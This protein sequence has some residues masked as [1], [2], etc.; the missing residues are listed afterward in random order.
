[1]SKASNPV[2]EKTP[3]KTPDRPPLKTSTNVP[4]QFLF[5]K[6]NYTLMFIGLGVIIL[7]FILMAG[8]KSP[9]PNVF[10]Y[11]EIYS[12]RRITIAPILVLLGLAIEGYAIMKRPKSIA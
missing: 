9:D 3:E 2:I 11:D 10:N 6:E 12:A 8:G 5:S 4:R 1:M 7:G